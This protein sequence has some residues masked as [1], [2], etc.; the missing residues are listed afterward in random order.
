MSAT[1]D[2]KIT[3]VLTTLLGRAPSAA[4]VIAG[5]TD[6]LVLTSVLAD[7][8]IGLSSLT[9]GP[10][11]DLQTAINNLSTDGGGVLNLQAGVYVLGAA[12]ITVPSNV[13]ISGAGTV[14]TQ[15]ICSPGYVV[16]AHGTSGTHITD[17]AFKNL[18]FYSG[19]A[20]TALD[21]QY[22]D[23]I[24]LENILCVGNN[25]GII[26]D[27][28]TDVNATTVVVTTST[29]YGITIS[30][31]SFIDMRSV[32]STSNGGVGLVLD[33][34]SSMYLAPGDFSSNTLSGITMTSCS[35][36]ILIVTGAS[37]GGDGLKMTGTSNSKIT[38]G[39]Y[40]GNG[41][42]GLNITD[43]GSDYNLILGNSFASNTTA[44]ANNS[45]TGT[46]IRSNIGL[47]D[48]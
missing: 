20:G 33:T 9:I 40:T 48:N 47:S 27:N 7:Y 16:K 18:G 5:R 32:N 37:N 6:S 36:V 13:T 10:S 12:D 31:S 1:L 21:I 3:S 45:G 4:E 19:S 30:N 23:R 8:N 43:S 17:I 38:F 42:Y 35:A 41:G 46:L 25:Q 39:A 24:V 15:I 34:V 11:D 22:A 2:A 44:A 26:I 28:C 14:N 29:G